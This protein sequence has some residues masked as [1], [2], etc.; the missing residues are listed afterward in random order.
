MKSCFLAVS[1]TL[2]PVCSL[3]EVQVASPFGD[4][5]VLQRE[6]GVPV[7][8]RAAVG[9]RV[10]VD[11]A[12]QSASAK[13][14]SEG[15]W[16]VELA[17]MTASVEA[18][19]LV[20]TGS[21]TREAIVFKDVLVGDVWLCGGQ[22]N[23]ERQLGPRGGQKDIIGWQEEA[24]AAAYPMIRELYVKQ[25]R[26]LRP[27]EEVEAHWRVCTPESVTD[28]TAV[29]Y[30]FA[31][32][33]HLAAG[34]PVGIIHSSWGGTPAEAWTSLEGMSLFPGYVDQAKAQLEFAG[35]P[36]EIKRKYEEKLELWFRENDGSD[37]LALLSSPKSEWARMSLPAMWEDAGYPG[38]DGICWFR[39]SVV[40][41]PALRG[42]DL[43]LELGAIDDIDTTWVNGSLLGSTTGWQT[44]REYR[45][46]SSL[47][48]EGEI[49]ILVRVLDTGGGG[50]IWNAQQPLR[51]SQAGNAGISLDLAGVWESRFTLQL[52]Q[53]PW[54]P[55][56][57]SQNPG[58]PTVLFNAMI[59]PLVPYALRG[60]VFY[61]GEA[62][63][64]KA[65]EYERLLPALIADW[66]DHWGAP[67]LPF[68]YV[69]IAPYEGMPPEIREAQRLAEKA[70]ENTAM[71]VTIDVGDAT[72]IHPANKEPV[73]Q[74]LALAARALSYGE[75]IVY[76][77]PVFES[78]RAKG[79]TARIRFSSTGSGLLAKG[80]E[81][82]GFEVAG[83]DGAFHAAKA[84]IEDDE[85]VLRSKQ[86]SLVKAVRYGWANVA[87]GNLF[88]KEGLPASPFKAE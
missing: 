37:P 34:V 82:Y 47:T 2:I 80:G 40:L 55:Q 42:K 60:F 41:P 50:G 7:W 71:V 59:A 38:V 88:N 58:A 65:A 39:K 83:R 51:I 85:V 44:P 86:V 23:M 4:H 6:Q 26:D 35:D 73:G 48:A 10:Q 62:N 29:G 14:D 64:G 22:S 56:D 5:M 16:K 21:A 3:A 20:V 12:G 61:Q 18:R 8:G 70:T 78:W 63:A 31:R 72:D 19:E 84:T 49:A 24:A 13:A 11:F 87:E 30:F 43:L 52:G 57:L 46:P 9:E 54:P 74:R 25:S 76:S 17:P 81:L 75:E 66:R 36:D 68:L 27:Q 45:I 69:Q 79:K 33:V 28:F 15:E 77:G 67:N 32:D 53:G 1:L